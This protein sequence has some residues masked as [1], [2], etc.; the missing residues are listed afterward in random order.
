MEAKRW[1]MHVDMD[2]FFASVEQLDHPEYRGKPVIVGGLSE[3]GVVATASYE[4]RK[5]G[6]HS[7]L[8]MVKAR[9]LCPNGI[10]IPGRFD[11]Y[12][13]LSEKIRTI[14]HQFS[15]LVEPLSI[16]EALLDLTG[17]EQLLGTPLE[18]G[19]HIKEQIKKET[20]LTASVGIAPNKFLAKL[21]SDLE[22][23]DGLVLIPPEQAAKRI[24]DLPV[25]RI[26]GLGKKSVEALRQWGITT[27]GQLAVCDFSILRPL[28]GKSAEEIRDRANGLDDRPVV[29]DEKRKSLGKEITYGQDLIGKAACLKALWDLCQMVGWRLRR[30]GLSGYTVTLKIKT[31]RFQ[32]LTRSRTLEEPVQLDEELR[33]QVRILA[34]EVS[35]KEP[36]RLLGVSV[37]HLTEGG[38][39]SLS[40]DGRTEKASKQNAAL[41]AIKKRFG[42]DSIHK[43]SR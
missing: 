14:F 43:G 39:P 25:S 40:L 32:L 1:I 10:F 38:S 24:A 21:A 36:V 28:L 33:E 30:A 3:R 26:F 41:D 34:E 7:A 15:P 20:G 31:A 5:F 13:E 6:V 18:I 22:K 17:A 9:Q 4:A 2:A 27:I 8:S 37:S 16:D 42:E 19:R 29:P 12:R 23:P 35:W 11:R